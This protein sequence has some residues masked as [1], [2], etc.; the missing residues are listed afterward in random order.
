MQY[1]EKIFRALANH[2][3]LEI[4]R[5]LGDMRPR[6]VVAI[7]EKIKL[8]QKSTSKHLIMLAQLDILEKERHANMVHYS[9]NKSLPRLA[10][11]ILPF[12]KK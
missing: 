1:L 12:I 8:S 5:L 9:L 2:K 6:P 7:A 11:L 3:R 4:I 10:Q